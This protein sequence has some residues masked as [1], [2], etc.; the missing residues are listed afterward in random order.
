[1]ALQPGEEIREEVHED[2]NQFFRVQKGEGEFWID[3]IK[4]K[5]ESDTAMIVEIGR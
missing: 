4:T 1:M 3:G 2:R 5:I